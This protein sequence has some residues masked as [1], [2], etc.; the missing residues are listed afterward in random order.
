MYIEH[1]VLAARLRRPRSLFKNYDSFRIDIIIKEN[2]RPKHC[3]ICFSLPLLF[4][5]ALLGC[6]RVDAWME[7][8]AAHSNIQL[9]SAL[10][11]RKGKM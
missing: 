11:D 5:T 10:E 3:Q 8:G 6:L 7:K 9:G 4:E 1:V 2:D